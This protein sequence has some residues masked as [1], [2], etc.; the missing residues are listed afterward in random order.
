MARATHGNDELSE[1]IGSL[2]DE[3]AE[4]SVIGM[5]ELKLL[6]NADSSSDLALDHISHS[7]NGVTPWQFGTGQHPSASRKTLGS[8]V[9][10][11]ESSN[12]QNINIRHIVIEGSR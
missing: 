2:V 1:D 11:A 4:Y 12:G 6:L 3:G 5:I 10:T 7:P 8:T 9:L